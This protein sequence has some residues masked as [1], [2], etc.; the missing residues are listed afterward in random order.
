MGLDVEKG[1]EEGVFIEKG[2]MG[3]G[4]ILNLTHV[5]IM[6]IIGTGTWGVGLNMTHREYL[7]KDFRYRREEYGIS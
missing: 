7:R 5:F 1:R 3:V 2:G 4:S 6:D